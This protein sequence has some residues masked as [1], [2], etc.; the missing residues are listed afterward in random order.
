M[1]LLYN[2]FNEGPDGSIN[3][4][5]R[6]L[7]KELRYNR[8]QLTIDEF[9]Q[10]IPSL[11]QIESKLQRLDTDMHQ[12]KRDYI[13][14][15]LDELEQESENEASLANDLAGACTA[16]V[17]TLL[18]SSFDFDDL[19]FT[20]NKAKQYHWLQFSGYVDQRPIDANLVIV[21]EVFRSICYRYNY[22]FIDLS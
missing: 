20:T 5:L 15:I 10:A 4:M 9:K 14:E 1:N 22:T 11:K 19:L 8:S 3:G 21:K 13:N 18:N 16:I 6:T 12:P 7:V 2:E 17:T